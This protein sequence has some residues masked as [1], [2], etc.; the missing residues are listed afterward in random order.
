MT[1]NRCAAAD[2]MAVKLLELETE[3]AKALAG[4]GE[5]YVA[6]HHARGKMTARERAGV[7]SRA[8]ARHQN[9]RTRQKQ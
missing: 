4:G 7:I 3:H 5:K 8:R 6:R 1:N 9:C 2:A